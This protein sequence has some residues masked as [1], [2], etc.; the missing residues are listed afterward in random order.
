MEPVLKQALRAESWPERES[1]LVV[2]YEALA[3]KHNTLSKTKDIDKIT[4]TVIFMNLPPGNAK[5]T[6]TVSATGALHSQT[7]I[8]I[9]KGTIS[10]W[11][12]VPMP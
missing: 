1:H 6:V 12:A 3:A 11:V 7:T 8:P 4:G 10:G 5:V 9:R 2:A